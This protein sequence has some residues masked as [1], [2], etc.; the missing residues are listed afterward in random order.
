MIAVVIPTRN[1]ARVILRRLG[2][3]LIARWPETDS[4]CRVILVDDGSTDDTVARA[5]EWEGGLRSCPFEFEVISND[6][7][8]GK[9]GAIRAGLAVLDERTKLVILTDADVVVHPRA[10]LATL[11]AFESDA[12]LGM[13]SGSQR[14]VRDLATDGSLRAA[15]LGGLVSA[16]SMYDRLTGLVR[17]VESRFGKLVS[18]HGQWLAWRAELDLRPTSGIAAD[19]L[20]LLF[21]VRSRGHRVR[22][23]PEALFVEERTSKDA[24]RAEQGLRRARAWFQVFAHARRPLLGRGVVD[25]LQALAYATLPRWAPEWALGALV[26][27][28]LGVFSGGPW[29]ALGAPLAVL[30]FCLFVWIP[31]STIRR[32]RSSYGELSD[33]WDQAR[34]RDGFGSGAGTAG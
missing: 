4:V 12:R 2:N 16:D 1:E 31:I 30:G 11:D 25:R 24:G 9:A 8:P 21:Q 14:F 20:D 13:A 3:L 18:V 15:N 28:A 17:A 33:R 19:D 22:R 32:A 29:R 27:G 10:L 5:L 6:G 23:V 26:F 34:G 7:E